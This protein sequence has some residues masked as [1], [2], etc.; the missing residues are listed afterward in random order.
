MSRNIQDEDLD[1]ILNEVDDYNID[2]DDDEPIGPVDEDEVDEILKEDFANQTYSMNTDYGEPINFTELPGPKL[3]FKSLASSTEHPLDI[4]EK[5]EKDLYSKL[6]SQTKLENKFLVTNFVKQIGKTD[7]N[8]GYTVLET[9]SK[10]C[11]PSEVNGNLD[12]DNEYWGAPK[13][14]AVSI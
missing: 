1:K 10:R 14:L 5:N 9:I 11:F 7:T 8:V 2:D 12:T 4:I 6:G 3:E 13:C